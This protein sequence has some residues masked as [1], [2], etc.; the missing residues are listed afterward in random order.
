[1]SRPV[2]IINLKNYPEILGESALRL[3]RA[4]ERVSAAV[5]VDIIIA[6]PGPSLAS[7][8]SSVRIPVF[9]QS[10]EDSVEGKSTGRVIPEALRAWGCAGSIINHSESK[11]TPEVVGRL[12]AR[13]KLSG[14]TSCVCAETTDEVARMAALGPE[15]VAVEP[16]ELIGTGRSVS[17]AKPEL[18]S[19]S[20]AAARGRRYG[21]QVLC[22]AGI[23]TAEDVRTAVALGAR[24]ILVSSSVVKAADWEAKVRELASALL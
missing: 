23:V 24:G 11:T 6:P 19:G 16:P 4:A 17:R 7:I 1:L 3:A 2:F 5:E 18:V 22:G 8:A 21:G 10:V 15:Y 14:L 9:S 13:M 12:V 20:V